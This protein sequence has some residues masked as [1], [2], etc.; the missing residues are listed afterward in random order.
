VS[1]TCPEGGW[2]RVSTG[3]G[4]KG[5]R[6]YAWSHLP[7]D[8]TGAAPTGW[9]RWLL[10]RRGLRTG[11]L[12]YYVCA[13]PAGLPLVALVRVAGSRWRVEEAFQTGKGLA[14][15]DQHQV[16]RWR[17]WYRWVTLAIRTLHGSGWAASVVSY[18]SFDQP[19]G[20]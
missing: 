8:S 4:A 6:W 3:Q 16:R 9:Q 7:L 18:R 19:R 20:R 12:A 17:S 15:L 2:L 1:C 10:A 14:G 13:G 5:R 11:E